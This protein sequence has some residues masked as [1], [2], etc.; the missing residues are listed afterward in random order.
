MA[1]VQRRPLKAISARFAIANWSRARVDVAASLAADWRLWDRSQP[2]VC[3][4]VKSA[5]GDHSCT[6]WGDWRDR[7]AGAQRYV[8]GDLAVYPLP[9]RPLWHGTGRAGRR[10]PG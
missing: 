8:C 1:D 4:R 5:D 3:M 7:G 9:R 2:G 10:M 6:N